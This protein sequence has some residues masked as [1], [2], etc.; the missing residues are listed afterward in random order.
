MSQQHC[1]S[2]CYDSFKFSILGACVEANVAWRKLEGA[3]V[4]VAC[5][6]LA[7]TTAVLFWAAVPTLALFCQGWLWCVHACCRVL[8]GRWATME[9]C[10][11]HHG[12]CWQALTRRRGCQLWH[13]TSEQEVYSKNVLRSPCWQIAPSWWKN[14][15]IW[16]I[17]IPWTLSWS[18]V[19]VVCCISS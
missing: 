3:A 4:L 1:Q 11:V 16:V 18:F 19:T 10:H 17:K 15:L 6:C 5:F 8:C 7:L 13:Q 2:P 12:G 9:G 14:C